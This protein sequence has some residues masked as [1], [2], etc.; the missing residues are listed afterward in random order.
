MPNDELFAVEDTSTSQTATPAAESTPSEPAQEPQTPVIE[1]DLTPTAEQQDILNRIRDAS[2]NTGTFQLQNGRV[3][4]SKSA[5][6]PT[7]P[8]NAQPQTP[9]QPSQTQTPEQSEQM[10]ELNWRGQIVQKPISEVRNLAQKGFDYEAK[11]FELNRQRQELDQMMQAVQE[12]TANR[13]P[14]QQQPVQPEQY[15][16]LNEAEISQQALAAVKAKYGKDDPNFEF[17][18]LSPEQAAAYNL[19]TVEIARRVLTERETRQAQENQRKATELRLSSWENQ[20][21]SSDPQYDSVIGWI[22]EPV[23]FDAQN[24]PIPRLKQLLTAE[25]YSAAD[26]ALR[27][28]DVATLSKVVNFC[29]VKYQQQKLGLPTKPQTVTPPVVQAPGNGQPPQS[30]QSA[31]KAWPKSEHNIPQE[32][33]IELW[34]QR[35]APR[36]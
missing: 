35:F 32:A 16:E 2:R 29:K 4:V 21:R 28:G 24:Q 12:L 5:G 18:P 10:V 31:A 15:T 25:Q 23:G 1:T 14:V 20:Q 17:D 9:A 13:P 30:Q 34:K 6:T 27:T 26:E 3:V 11:S 19:A 36:R 8:Q 33:R 22:V 7:A